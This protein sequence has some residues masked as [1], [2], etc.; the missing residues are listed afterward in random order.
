MSSNK[1][2]SDLATGH[3]GEALLAALFPQLTKA[4][5]LAYDLVAPNGTKLEVKYDT[6]KYQNIFLEII[7][8][9]NKQSPGAVFQSMMKGAD[10]FVYIFSRDNSIRTFKVTDL[11]WFLYL[12]KSKYEP[13]YVSNGSY[14]TIG[15]AVPISDLKHLEL[16]LGIL[17]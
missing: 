10:Y 17:I 7:S 2:H 5:T 3:K 6:T 8:N 13:R 12:H 15:V 9:N 4:P 11:I 1:F 16:D 14:M